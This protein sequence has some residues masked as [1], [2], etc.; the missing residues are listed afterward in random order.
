MLSSAHS[1]LICV[2][3]LCFHPRFQLVMYSENKYEGPETMVVAMDIG[4]T[5]S[6]QGSPG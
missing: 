5:Q 4:T 1:S 3:R 6:E 2:S